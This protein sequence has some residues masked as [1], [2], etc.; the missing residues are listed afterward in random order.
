V[1]PRVDEALGRLPPALRDAVV[2]RHLHGLSLEETARMT[3]CPVGEV[4]LRLAR[5]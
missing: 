3:A 5:G 1:N 2:L 4:P